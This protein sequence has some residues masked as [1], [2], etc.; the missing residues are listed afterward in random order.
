MLMGLGFI[1]FVFL[2][3]TSEYPFR[4]TWDTCGRLMTASVVGVLMGGPLIVC[5]K[6]QFDCFLNFLAQRDRERSDRKLKEVTDTQQ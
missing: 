3:V 2:A 6:S 4:W 1:V 5:G